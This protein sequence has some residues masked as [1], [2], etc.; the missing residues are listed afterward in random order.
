MDPGGH[1]CQKREDRRARWAA[2]DSAYDGVA[3]K[4]ST[5]EER[6]RACLAV[7]ITLGMS[8]VSAVLQLFDGSGK[9]ARACA[10][11]WGEYMVRGLDIDLAVHFRGPVEWERP[12]V[13]MANHNSHLDIPVLYAALPRVFGMLAKKSLFRFPIFKQAMTGIGCVPIERGDRERAKVAIDRA[14][15]LVRGGQSIVVFPE[16]TR[17][18][19]R[20]VYPFKMGGFHLVR[21]AG[22]PVLPVGIRGTAAV[23][24]KN[25]FKVF[26]GTVE[27]HV[28]TLMEPTEPPAVPMH[29]DPFV[30]SVRDE[31]A[32]LSGYPVV[33]PS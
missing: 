17:G 20:G 12:M 18:D 4:R 32:A 6:A 30:R 26:P 1:F 31:I 28:G 5:M 14:A 19:G 25:T 7:G 16:G 15:N 11:R 13:V 9:S 21:A 27:V 10:R 8:E 3:G 24:P 23:C 22:V 29:K 33:D 2:Q